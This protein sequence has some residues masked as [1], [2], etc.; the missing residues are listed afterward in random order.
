MALFASVHASVPNKTLLLWSVVFT[1][2]FCGTFL[3]CSRRKIRDSQ[4]LSWI[5]SSHFFHALLI[6]YAVVLI[7]K[8]SMVCCPHAVF[9]VAALDDKLWIQLAWPYYFWAVLYTQKFLYVYHPLYQY[10]TLALALA[11]RFT[12]SAQVTRD[13]HPSPSRSFCSL[14]L[15]HKS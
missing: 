3:V 5:N 1:T 11:A 4:D 2:Q 15:G 7:M 14:C 10:L 12:H 13:G 6:S 8:K 9:I